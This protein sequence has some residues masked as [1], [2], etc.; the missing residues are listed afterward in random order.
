MKKIVTTCIAISVS[1]LLMAQ[2]PVNLKFNLA[3]DK[4]YRLK[5]SSTENTTVTY[6][7]TPQQIETKSISSVS[8]KPINLGADFVIAEV[9]FDT[10][11]T[12][13]SMPKMELN[14]TK[15]GKLSSND[16]SEVMNCI[17]NRL[18][19]AVFN[20]KFSLSGKVL[21]ISNL[22]ANADAITQGIDS[23]QGQM[24]MAKGRITAMASEAAIKGMIEIITGY[25]PGKEIVT[26]DK[27][28]SSIILN[29]GGIGMNMTYNY[30]LK[31]VTGTQAEITG[32]V[33]VE[34]ASQTPTE[35]N[36]AQISYDV[37]GLGKSTL[38]VDAKTGWI[39]KAT[40]KTHNQGNMNIKMQGN[41][42]QMPVETDG[43]TEII[44]LP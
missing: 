31:K 24:A 34:P 35:M 10:I 40:I 32:D 25:L 30:K 5:S 41:D 12:T 37:R 28:T 16:P 26:G 6:G 18:S 20:V 21:E 27:W 23:L 8:I 29:S 19:K 13:I 4:T 1:V 22:K 42:M 3:K 38:T 36:G 9:R 7:G 44:S 15:P 17:M 2:T 14:S 33:T 11:M 43:T 39:L